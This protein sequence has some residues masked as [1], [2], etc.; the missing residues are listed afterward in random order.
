[1]SRHRAVS[2]AGTRSP[3]APSARRR[4]A[5]ARVG[6]GCTPR[7]RRRSP[8]C[9]PPA[10]PTTPPRCSTFRSR[11][12]RRRSRRCSRSSRP[13]RSRAAM[14]RPRTGT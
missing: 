2:R 10:K 3:R 4:G 7:R 6:R 5:A 14:R 8:G 13:D 11:R 1:V 12:S 9:W